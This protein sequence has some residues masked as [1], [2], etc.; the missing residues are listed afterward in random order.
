MRDVQ[1]RRNSG[2]EIDRMSRRKGDLVSEVEA[3]ENRVKE[4]EPD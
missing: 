1:K 4:R 2:R 3:A